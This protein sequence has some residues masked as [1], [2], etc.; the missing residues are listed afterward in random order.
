VLTRS[1]GA[2]ANALDKLVGLGTAQMV[3]DKPRTYQ[4]ATAATAPD[5]AGDPGT[6]AEATA[7]AA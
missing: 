4:L 7:S 6:S 3:T 2:V 5:A 1:A